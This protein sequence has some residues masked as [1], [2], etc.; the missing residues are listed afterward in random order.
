MSSGEMDGMGSTNGMGG[1]DMGGMMGNSTQGQ[2]MEI[3][4]FYVDREGNGVKTVPGVLATINSYDPTQAKRTRIFT[5][6]MQGMTH[7]INGALYNP[8][9]VDLSIPFGE[10]ELW[11]FRNASDEIHPMHPHG[12]LFQVLDRN[13]N[14]NLPPEDRGWKDTV[15]VWPKETVRILIRFD[16]Y[17]GIFVSHCHNLEHED[18]GMMQNLEVLPPGVTRLLVQRQSNRLMI[19]YPGAMTN[20][21]LEV[22]ETLGPTARWTK[23]PLMANGNRF[24][25]PMDQPSVNRFYRLIQP[26]PSFRPV[27]Q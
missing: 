7:T 21:V 24:D 19:T 3:L 1:H 17:A 18:T 16:A 2:A 27:H 4:R 25:I 6:D 8:N 9:R 12:A 13:S 23:L 22:S 15:L 26:T 11:E 14:T 5:L 10:L 20:M